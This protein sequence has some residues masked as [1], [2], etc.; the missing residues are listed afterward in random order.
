MPP[1]LRLEAMRLI[2]GLALCL[3]LTG[4][5]SIPD[6]VT[7][8]PSDKATPVDAYADAGD[9][10]MGKAAAS[11]AV[12]KEANQSG[13]PGV[14]DAEL[15]V[16]ATLLPRPSPAD[17]AQAKARADKADPKAYAKAAEEADRL[18]REL[19]TLWAKVEHEKAKAILAL[20]AKQQELDAA[21]A[22]QRDLMWT[23]AGL[24]LIVLGV[25]SIAW[26]SAM[27]ISKFEAGLIMLCGFAVGSLPWL[28]ESDL[29]AWVLAPAAGL[30][31]L[32]GVVWVWSL[33][34]RKTLPITH[35]LKPKETNEISK[36]ENH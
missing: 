33:G 31:A 35:F 9:V 3:S 25:A 2:L 11:V 6:E 28:L 15:G 1:S 29:S 19:D 5:P 18:Q 34:K 21:R 17:L 10:V 14:V 8:P 32:R 23:G 30:V 12:A 22:A 13:K 7:L 4:C 20:D 27:G 16:A 36:G 24:L 26:G